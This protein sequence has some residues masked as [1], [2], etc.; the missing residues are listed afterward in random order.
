M[1]SMHLASCRFISEGTNCVYICVKS[2]TSNARSQLSL[3]AIAL[4]NRAGTCSLLDVIQELPHLMPA[5][6]ANVTQMMSNTFTQATKSLA[7]TRA[8]PESGVIATEVT[9]LTPTG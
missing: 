8:K 7:V 4:R 9:V 1:S 3:N 6:C 5:S 2:H